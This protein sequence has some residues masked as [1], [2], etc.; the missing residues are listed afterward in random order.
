MGCGLCRVCSEAHRLKYC[1]ENR[2]PPDPAVFPR[3][4]QNKQGLWLH[5]AEWAPPRSVPAVRAVLFII[6]GLGEH[7]ARYDSVGLHFA[8]LGYHVFNMDNQGAGGSEGE[9]LYV[10]NFYDF[11]DDFIQFKKHALSLYPEYTKLP[12]FLLGHSMGGLIATHVA[13]REP[14]TFDGVI[15]SGPALEPHPDVASPIKM[16]VARKLSSCFPKM[17]VGSVE[18]KRVSTN[19][20]VVQFLEQDPYY[21]KPPLRARWAGEMLR[22]MGDVW[23]LME[24]STFAVLVLHGTKDELCPLSGSRKFIEATVCEDKKLIEYPGLGHEVLTEVRREEVLGDVEKFLEA[25]LRR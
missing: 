13:L 25:H 21:F 7:T 14:S 17:G 8:S 1:G 16:W 18:G 3:Y 24:K 22:A 15:L 10:E 5:F 9:R 4:M 19:Q 2:T 11:V 6:S 12:C 23:P 20:Q